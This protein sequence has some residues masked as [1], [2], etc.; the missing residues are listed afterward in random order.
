MR[1]SRVG[2][3]LL[4][5]VVLALLATP[6]L[7]FAQ[8]GGEGEHP[9]AG[10][11]IDMAIL[12]IG[13]WIPSSLA[14]DLAMSDFAPYAEENFGYT[15]NF[16]FQEAPF[17]NL[18]QKAATSL[19][20]GS[21]EFNIIVSDSQWLGAFAEPGWIVNVS[22]L[23]AGD[24][25][26]FDIEWY[27]PVVSQ[28]YQYYP[29]GTENIWGLPE[30]G[31][32]VVLYVNKDL[33]LDP[34]ER[35]NFEAEYGWAMPETYEDWYDIDFDQFEQMIEFFTR[36]E[37]DLYGTAMQYSKEYDFM[38]MFLYPFMFSMGG[39]IWDAETGN[40]YGIL[41]SDVNVEA[42]EINR[43][44]LNYQPPGALNYG[45]PDVVD[46]FT[47]DKV[48]SGFQWAAMGAGMI[49][50]GSEEHYMVVVPPGF[51][52]EDGSVQ[53]IYS[54]GGQPWVINAFNDEAHM[55]VAMDFLEWWYLP[56]TQLAFSEGGGNPATAAAMN[57]EGFEDI[58]VWNRAYKDM[59][60]EE[61]A[62]DF[63]HEP[64][65]AEMLAVQQEGW[66]AFASGQVDDPV[67]TLEWI[68]CQQ[69]EI[70]YDAGRAADPAPD[71]CND[72]TLQ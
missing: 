68:A 58:N 63:W 11:T 1:Q 3:F 65:Y 62:R 46:V 38:T 13:G 52:M 23:I 41:N 66:T 2:K 12:G 44:W 50:P 27:D 29:D 33:L 36:P 21:Q 60:T 7:A 71:S 43:R 47:Q 51:R 30:T 19:A 18:F 16:T 37:E 14:V 59:L 26:Q 5:L 39:D 72:V 31:D 34:E 64:T 35:A 9:L 6:T 15:V 28:A 25:P 67:N 55:R 61:T 32:V 10:Q 45:I 49:P 20:T 8:G 70:L 53:R 40:V 24:Y 56:E 4:V 48:F 54:I 22:D 42:M 17:S 57:A 69:Q